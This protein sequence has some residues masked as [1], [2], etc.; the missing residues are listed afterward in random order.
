VTLT[1]ELENGGNLYFTYRASPAP[2]IS[3]SFHGAF[4][5]PSATAE[6]TGHGSFQLTGPLSANGCVNGTNDH[7]SALVRIHKHH[8]SY[9]IHLQSFGALYCAHGPS[10]RSIG[11]TY[12]VTKSTA[13][14]LPVGHRVVIPAYEGYKNS[15]VADFCDLRP[16][17]HPPPTVKITST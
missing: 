5:S 9:T 7:G 12:R 13:S 6:I 4:H 17:P 2:K 1:I 11:I 15:I 8:G 16:S 10:T 14:C 3:Y